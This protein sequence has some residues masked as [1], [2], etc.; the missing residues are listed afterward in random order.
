VNI[1]AYYCYTGILPDTYN[2]PGSMN[3]L[4]NWFIALFAPESI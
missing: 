1:L 4:P 2:G 3:Y